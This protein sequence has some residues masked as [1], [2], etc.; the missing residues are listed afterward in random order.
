M[1]LFQKCI[2]ALFSAVILASCCSTYQDE[3]P[4]CT[5]TTAEI[6]KKAV[7]KIIIDSEK[8]SAE[9]P[10]LLVKFDKKMPGLPKFGL[11]KFQI[12]NLQ[13]NPGDRYILL[14]KSC[15]GNI[16]KIADAYVDNNCTLILSAQGSPQVPFEEFNTALGGCCPGESIDFVLATEDCQMGAAAHVVLDPL[17][18]KFEDGATVTVELRSKHGELYVVYLK[19]FQPDEKLSFE[20]QSLF[21]KLNNEIIVDNTGSHS[22]HV[23]P[24]VVGITDGKAAVIIT[25]SNGK[26]VTINYPWGPGNVR[27]RQQ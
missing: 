1:T 2:P 19:G 15:Q 13:M 20:S 21:E 6:D 18:A 22:F 25:R 8:Q 14:M 23:M 5:F 3:I 7:N 17:E 4:S 24:Q 16:T 10:Q 11:Y 27:P 26:Q 12:C 9:A